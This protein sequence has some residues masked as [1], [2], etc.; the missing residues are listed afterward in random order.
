MF[1][2]LD[3]FLACLDLRS[4]SSGGLRGVWSRPRATPERSRALQ[5]NQKRSRRERRQ[6]GS[7]WAA[8]AT[9]RR[10]QQEP[11]KSAQKGARGRPGVPPRA[12]GGHKNNEHIKK[13]TVYADFH[14]IFLAAKSRPRGPKDCPRV[15]KDAEEPSRALQQRPHSTLG[16][17]QAPCPPP[18]SQHAVVICLSPRGPDTAST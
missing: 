1:S 18:R 14:E 15:P 17:C 7:K 12:P 9:K 4:L 16:R 3:T 8:R 2:S 6:E 13:H 5:E 10:Q 11:P